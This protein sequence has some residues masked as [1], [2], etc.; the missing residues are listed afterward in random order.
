MTTTGALK[1]KEVKGAATAV[2]VAAK[3]AMPNAKR[4][5]LPFFDIHAA[6]SGSVRTVKSMFEVPPTG[7]VLGSSGGLRTH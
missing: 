3:G 2:G 4:A 6:P 5:A 1:L 7:K